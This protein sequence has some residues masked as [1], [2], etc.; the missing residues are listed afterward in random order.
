MYV[1]MSVLR[2]LTDTKIYW[3]GAKP[4]PSIPQQ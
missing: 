2:E 3:G 4:E 1:R